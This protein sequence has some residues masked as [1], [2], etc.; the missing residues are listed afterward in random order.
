LASTTTSAREANVV[1]FIT[2]RP[3]SATC[4]C[5]AG[6][7]TTNALEPACD[8]LSVNCIAAPTVT[9]SSV[10]ALKPSDHSLRTNS[11]GV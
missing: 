1:P 4:L 7:P 8:W 5:R 11:S 6:A 10:E 2:R 3:A 9:I